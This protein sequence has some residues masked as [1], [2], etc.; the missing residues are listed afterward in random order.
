MFTEQEIRLIFS[1]PE[2]YS[3]FYWNP[4]GEWVFSYCDSM[5][6]VDLFTCKATETRMCLGD[7]GHFFDEWNWANLSWGD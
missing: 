4:G 7:T 2:C 1:I 6:T 3:G 5:I